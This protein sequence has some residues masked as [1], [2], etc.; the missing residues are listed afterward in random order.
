M[1]CDV[2]LTPGAGQQHCGASVSDQ[3]RGFTVR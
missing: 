1:V 2:V 3:S